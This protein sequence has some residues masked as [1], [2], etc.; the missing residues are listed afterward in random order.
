MKLYRIF[1]PKNYNNGRSIEDKTIRKITNQL[2]DKFG[3][4]TANPKA[5]LPILEGVWVDE[6]HNKSYNE[7]VICVELFCQD[8]YDSCRWLRSF[9]EET[10]KTLKQESL[11]VIV[12]NAE[13][14][15]NTN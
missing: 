12:Q 1:I 8:T 14:I 3:G 4:Y 7:N 10:R 6:K 11:F 15:T 9:T 5:R 2:R 13:I